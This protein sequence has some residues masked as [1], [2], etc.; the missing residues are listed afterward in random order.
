MLYPKNLDE[1]LSVEL[2][3]NPTSEY[4]GTPFWAWNCQLDKDTLFR[5]IDVLKTMGMGGFHIHS[6]TGMATKYLGDEFMELVKACNDKAKSNDML[7]WLYDEDRWPS[8]SAGGYV[9]KDYRYRT[10]Y[11]VFTPM[12]LDDSY[13]KDKAEFNRAV[14]DNKKPKGYFI[15]K[16]E[17]VIKSGFLNSYK[18]LSANDGVKKDARVW[19]AYMEIAQDYPWY[20]NQAY[21]NT[22]DPEAIKR[23]VEVTHEKYYSILGEEFGR[24]IPAIFTDEP[25]FN[26]KE[27]LSFAEEERRITIPFTDNFNDTYKQTYGNDILDFLPELFWE[28]PDEEISVARYRYHDH[29]SERFASSFADIIGDWCETHGIMLTGHMME[30]PTLFSQTKA[31]GEA[32]R[33]YRSFQLPGIDML[34]D[35]REFSTVKQAQSAAHQYGRPGVLSE[36]YGVTNWD[37]DFKGHKLQG[38]WQAALGVTVRAH[39]LAWVSMGG[40]AKRDYPASIG[41]QS[42]WYKEYRLIEDYFSRLNTALTRGTPLVRIGV[43]HPIESYWLYWGPLEQ[44]FMDRDELESNFNNVVQWLLFGLLDFDFI[45]E[46]LLPMQSTEEVKQR[47]K[48]GAMEYDVLLVPGCRTLRLTTVERL[49]SFIGAGGCVVFMGEPAKL[50]D[51]EKSDR[52]QKLAEKCI[53]IPFSKKN[54]IS[55]LEGYRDVDIRHQNGLRPDNL[56]YQMRCDGPERWLF[57]CHV[58]H[59][60]VTDELTGEFEYR[61]NIIIKIKGIWEPVIYDAIDGKIYPCPAAIKGDETYIEYEFSIHDSILLRLKPGMHECASV[62]SVKSKPEINIIEINDPVNITLSEPN[63]FLLDM[64]EYSFD[65]GPWQ[66]EEEI[67]RIDNAFRQ[68]LGYP[69]KVDVMAQPWVSGED[70]KPTHQLGLKFVFETDVEIEKASFAFENYGSATIIMNGINIPQKVN[71]WYVDESIKTVELPV[72]PAG[73]NEIVLMIPFGPK[74]NI[75]W[76]YLLGSFGVRVDGRYKR[77]VEPVR[78]ISFGN[79]TGQGLPFYAGN[80]THH[81]QFNSEGGNMILEVPHFANPLLSVSIDGIE[82]GRIAFAPYTLNLGYVEKGVHV[83][84]INAFGN[85]FNAFGCIHNCNNQ[86]RWF[87]PNAWRTSGYSWSYQY[88]LKPMG[89][90]VSPTIHYD[91]K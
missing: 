90:L 21:V 54:L 78:T 65:G 84:S 58:R 33:S 62:P 57:I 52:V 20:N 68:K 56:L 77:I 43:I 48:V 50:I 9:T 51:A 8:G 23:F 37:F 24:S 10:R 86:Y 11:I 44:T 26:H 80:V 34:C 13:L 70:E 59:K 61:E 6:R 49:E 19:W 40:E 25:Q 55:V 28:L 63:V 38:D 91:Y 46:S 72:I 12:E 17:V 71:G 41:Y 47:M 74:T 36:L 35:A 53:T 83:I 30:E 5:Q 60:P 1:V 18:R 69:L 67:L 3:K 4:R 75:E 27:V 45:S 7:C 79:W 85:R 32:M 73:E 64:A 87:G 15:A 42:P 39:H 89:I 66:K 22:L 14:M 16:Y 88:N 29:L 76:C 82:K 31:L 2:F 81:C